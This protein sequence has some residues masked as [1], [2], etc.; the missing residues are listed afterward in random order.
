MNIHL[1]PLAAVKLKLLI[2][3]EKSDQPLAIRVIPLTS[4]CNTPSFALE[5]TE[6]LDKYETQTE[7]GILFAWLPSEVAWMDGLVI[8]LNRETGKFSIFH[9][10]PPFM[11]ECPI[12][13]SI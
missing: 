13:P 11:G 6:V 12:E 5:I 3:E 10:N 1:S 9:P 2:M 4:G 7:Q 8:D